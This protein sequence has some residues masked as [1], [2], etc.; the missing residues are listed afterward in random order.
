MNIGI[1]QAGTLPEELRGTFDDYDD[2]SRAL[3]KGQ[4]FTFTTYR[5][6]DDEL[7]ETPNAQEGWLITDSKFA[8]YEDHAF[9]P[10]A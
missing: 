1:L 7:P 9:I 10:P 2:M 3:F 6:F 5:V 4:G 8:V